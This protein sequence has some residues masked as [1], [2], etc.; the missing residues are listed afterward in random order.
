MDGA[1]PGY[2]PPPI[3]DDGGLANQRWAF[4]FVESSGGAGVHLYNPPL[5]SVSAR[6]FSDELESGEAL[7]EFC[8]GPRT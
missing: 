6:R 8:A 2:G 7:L 5:N 1:R 3:L 4:V